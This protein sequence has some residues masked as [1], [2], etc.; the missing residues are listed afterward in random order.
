MPGGTISLDKGLVD[1]TC[2]LVKT[3]KLEPAAAEAKLKVQ[4]YVK[5][6]PQRGGTQ[7]DLDELY[8]LLNQVAA[9]R[10]KKA[11][12]RIWKMLMGTTV[13]LAMVGTGGAVLVAAGPA[14]GYAAV[15]AGVWA[16]GATI[17]GGGVVGLATLTDELRA[18]LSVDARAMKTD[19]QMHSRTYPEF[20]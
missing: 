5:Q 19:I 16:G 8:G 2:L 1:Y 18:K 14:L 3:E 7:V 13:A 20:V 15:S 17:A 11:N 12:Y 9:S 6:H 4:Q 10:D